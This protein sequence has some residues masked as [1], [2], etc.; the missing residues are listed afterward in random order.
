MD[1]KAL[2]REYKETP[3]PAGSSGYAIRRR[4]SPCW[5]QAPIFPA[6]SIARD[7]SLRTAPIPIRNSNETGTNSVRTRSS[8]RRSI[9]WS[10]QMSRVRTYRMTYECSSSCGGTSSQR[11]ERH[12]IPNPT[13][14]SDVA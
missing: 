9:F 3:Q 13:E 2:I 1:R 11:P 5:I 14:V 4:V 8:S 6:L 7:F 12:C 10:P